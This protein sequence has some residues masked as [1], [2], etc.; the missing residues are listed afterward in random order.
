MYRLVFCGL[1]ATLYLAAASSVGTITSAEP[2]LLSGTRVPVAGIPN[3]PVLEGDDVVMASSPGLI[4]FRDGTRVYLLP[5]SKIKISADQQGTL[6]RLE[7]GGLAYKFSNNSRVNLSALSNEALPDNSR[8][9][10]LSVNDGEVWWNPA[11]PSF[12]QMAGVILAPDGEYYFGQYRLTLFN[13]DLAEQWRNY[14]PGW[15]NAPGTELPTGPAPPGPVVVP[16][17]PKPV[18]AWR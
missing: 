12:Y 10:R 13:L 5:N 7:D 15:G 16:P 11:D 18:S 9:G 6:V 1:I 8:E 4:I 17:E 3:W 2:F 14:N